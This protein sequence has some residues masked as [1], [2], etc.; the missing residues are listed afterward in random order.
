MLTFSKI[1][2]CASGYQINESRQKKL[3]PG[4]GKCC[5]KE[6]T[7]SCEQDCAKKICDDEGGIW[8][9]LDYSTNP[10]T[11]EMGKKF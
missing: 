2:E 3:C 7:A 4:N 10:F 5:E 8:I 6:W 11:C 1:V 9:E